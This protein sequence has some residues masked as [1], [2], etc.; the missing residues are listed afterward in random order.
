MKILMILPEFEEGGVER[1]VLWLSTEFS[2]LGHRVMIATAGGRLEEKLPKEVRVIHL[3]VHRK[4]PVT[5][6]Y[7]A[8]RIAWTA[9]RGKI[10]LIHAHSRVPAWIAWWASRISGIPWVVTAHDRYRRN[11]AIHPFGRA[12]GAVCVSEAVRMHLDGAL[13]QNSTVIRNGIP[14]LDER[15][16]PGK[17]EPVYR[18]LFVG[19]LTRRKG[20]HVALHALSSLSGK[21]WML[22]ILGDGPQRQE[23][24]S[25]VKSLGLEGQVRFHGFRD[26]V[27][28]WMAASDCLLFPSLD[29]GMPLTLMQA[30]RV[31]IPVAASGIEPVKELVG[32]R[33]TLVPAG[34]IPAWT[35]GLAE[36]FR[37]EKTPPRFDPALVPT[38]KQ[39]AER[40]LVFLKNVCAD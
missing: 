23:L 19:R 16:R 40:T 34:D 3:P 12:N 6:L 10:D 2:A 35:N 21:P 13:P 38:A 17:K 33:E 24:E 30:I 15:W 31:G 32:D 25:M 20:L 29:E 22:D 18:F 36:I 4:N 5:A 27:G 14:D 7:S 39:M 9:W 1:H 8:L 28:R 11:A 37:E 26:E